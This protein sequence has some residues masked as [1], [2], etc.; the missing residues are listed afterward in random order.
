MTVTDVKGQRWQ[1]KMRRRNPFN[2]ILEYQRMAGQDFENDT[3]WRVYGY[4]FAARQRK[5]G[6]VVVP[7]M[8][9]DSAVTYRVEEGSIP[10]LSEVDAQRVVDFINA[11]T[12]YFESGQS[13]QDYCANKER[14]LGPAVQVATLKVWRNPV[15]G[16]VHENGDERLAVYVY[17]ESGTDTIRLETDI[18]A[19]KRDRL[20]SI[21]RPAL[22]TKA[23]VLAMRYA[24]GGYNP[25]T[26]EYLRSR[27]GMEDFV[28]VYPFG[29]ETYNAGSGLKRLGLYAK[30][31]DLYSALYA[32][33]AAHQRG[34]QQPGAGPKSLP[35]FPFEVELEYE[36]SGGTDTVSARIEY[37]GKDRLGLPRLEVTV[38]PT[39]TSTRTAY[40]STIWYE[41]HGNRLVPRTFYTDAKL[42]QWTAVLFNSEQQRKWQHTHNDG[43]TDS[44]KLP[45]NVRL[46]ED[47]RQR[48]LVALDA[49]YEAGLRGLGGAARYA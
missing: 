27:Y 1:V 8:L 14:K 6:Y 21:S 39:R 3:P 30:V 20:A 49:R 43:G 44:T 40:Y 42:L 48:V 23:S 38:D 17:P 22:F 5:D 31:S 26:L 15:A 36:Y 9:F 29:F 19:T 32:G 28:L 45:N 7:T 47:S 24:M 35:N 37:K 12:D 41:R 11:Y 33:W 10:L 34:W 4:T 46:S 13:S 2:F 25:T 16:G 18:E